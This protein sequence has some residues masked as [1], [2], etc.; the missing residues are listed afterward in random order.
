M[1]AHL[2]DAPIFQGDDL[3]DMGRLRMVSSSNK[4]VLITTQRQYGFRY[5]KRRG[6]TF[7]REA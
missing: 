3:V 1:T 5:L 2:D 6:K 4:I 7:M